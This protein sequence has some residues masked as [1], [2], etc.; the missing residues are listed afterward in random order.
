MIDWNA[1]EKSM[2]LGRPIQGI[3]L[4]KLA[5]GGRSL[6]EAAFNECYLNGADFS[7]CDLTRVKFIACDLSSADF[8]NAD[9][10]HAAFINCRLAG[11]VFH[12]AQLKYN[13]W[14]ECDLNGSRWEE[15]HSQLGA[16][17]N[18]Q[19]CDAKFSGAHFERMAFIGSC[20]TA[21][22]CRMQNSIRPCSIKPTCAR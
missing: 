14:T 15:T 3:D 1:I 19:A 9:L 10:T 12:A 17:I 8:R 20:R 7:N 18:S 16:V 5:A 21:L 4:R 6:T 13:C 11:A 22:T 2:R